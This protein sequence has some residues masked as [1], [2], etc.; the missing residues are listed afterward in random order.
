MHLPVVV[1]WIQRSPDAVLC[2]KKEFKGEV[3][4]E[5]DGKSIVRVHIQHMDRPKKEQEQSCR[6]KQMVKQSPNLIMKMSYIK[7]RYCHESHFPEGPVKE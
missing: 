7:R 1:I 3:H 2:R 6:R 5:N 4:K